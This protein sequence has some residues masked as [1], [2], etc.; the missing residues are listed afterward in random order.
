MMDVEG[1]SPHAAPEPPVLDRIDVILHRPQASENIGSVA[2]A[3]KNFGL[4]HLVLVAPQRYVAFKA[5]KLAKH[6]TDVLRGARRVETLDEAI[7]PYT[8]VI[9]TTERALPGRDGPLSPREAARLCCE[10]AAAGRVA[11]LFGEEAS[12]LTTATMARFPFYASVPTSPER[13]SLNLAQAVLLFAWEVYQEAG[14]DIL[15]ARPDQVRE[16]DVPAP[17]ELL[18]LLRSRGRDLLLSVGF[19]NP[20]DPDRALD[21]LLRLLQRGQPTRREAELLLAALAQVE[22][23]LGRG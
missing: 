2:R 13:R 1:D 17:A 12:G 6:A 5:E 18:T 21:E 10:R 16:G 22:R 4:K 23:V 19:L 11:L 20:Q 3:M 9:P 15:P 7:A 14:R 8:L